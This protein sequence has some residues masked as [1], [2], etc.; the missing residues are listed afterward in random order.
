MNTVPRHFLDLHDFD[1]ATLQAIVK[2]ARTMKE[3]RKGLPKGR[4]NMANP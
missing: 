2:R 3:A 4:V 1:G